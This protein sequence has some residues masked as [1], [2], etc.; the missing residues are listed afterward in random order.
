LLISP[1]P[2]KV[3]YVYAARSPFIETMIRRGQI[4]K[5]IKGLPNRY[6]D[7]EHLLASKSTL[8]IID[9][10][11]GELARGNYLPQVFEELTHRTNTA[12]VFVSQ[13]TFLNSPAF[14]RLSGT[15]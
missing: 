2:E 4:H 11:L 10:A 14:R 9:D 7:L 12:L 1:I 5:A 6:E 15:L 3:V 13:A 8:L